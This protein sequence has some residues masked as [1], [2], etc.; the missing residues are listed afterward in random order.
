M[1]SAGQ[2]KEIQSLK[3][4]KSIQD[5]L[6]KFDFLLFDRL[7]FGGRFCLDYKSIIG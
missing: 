5:Y 4:K 3:K 6:I 2:T 7:V 1:N